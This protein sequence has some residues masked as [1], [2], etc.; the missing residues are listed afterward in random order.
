[1]KIR[2]TIKS[3]ALV[4]TVAAL[5]P[6]GGAMATGPGFDNM[7]TDGAGVISG[8]PADASGN[9]VILM[10]GDG[11]LQQE[12]TIG[13]ETFIQTVIID[14]G[15]TAAGAITDLGFSDNT[16][17]QMGAGNGI[18]G[19]QTLSEAGAAG[20]GN[21]FEASTQ[22][23]IGWAETA[24]TANLTISQAFWD[25]NNTGTVA[26]PGETASLDTDD[27]VNTFTLGV[28]LDVNGNTTGKSMSMLQDVGMSDPS[29]TGNDFQRF[30]IEQRSGDLLTSANVAGTI[31]GQVS[32]GDGTGGTATWEATDD[33]MAVWLGQRVALGELGASRFGFQSITVDPAATPAVDP[34]TVK[35]YSR[36]ALDLS[37]APFSW[38]TSAGDAMFDNFGTAPVMPP[39]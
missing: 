30:I 25:N 23:L 19:N 18:M 20:T 26:S 27:F 8:C 36:T 33:V 13:T 21:L 1:M 28:N 5:L 15:A 22:L 16:F 11:F 37:A 32:S 12:V 39:P 10:S 14:S 6:V 2:N 9:C 17:I 29:G 24:G 4:G 31:L 35:T 38:G 7:V 3:L 34:S